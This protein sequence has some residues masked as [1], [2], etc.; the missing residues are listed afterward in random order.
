MHSLSH[1]RI[2]DEIS[3][4]FDWNPPVLSPA[5]PPCAEVVLPSAFYHLHL[6]ERLSL[7]RIIAAPS[8]VSDLSKTVDRTL[9]EIQDHGIVLTPLKEDDLFP[10]PIVRQLRV[11]KEPIINASSVAASYQRTTARHCKIIASMLFI[12]PKSPIWATILLWRQFEGSAVANP[13]LDESYALQMLEEDDNSALKASSDLWESID[14]DTRLTLRRAAKKYPILAL[15][16]VL[17]ITP[18]NEAFLKAAG[19]PP[20]QNLH[21]EDSP[22]VAGT[23]LST[24]PLH[25]PDATTLS[26]G[27]PISS[28]VGDPSLGVLSSGDSKGPSRR[29]SRI[30]KP[31]ASIK[32]TKS[33]ATQTTQHKCRQQDD[34]YPITLPSQPSLRAEAE[35]SFSKS[36][37]KHVGF[38]L[39]CL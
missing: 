15:W 39:P 4:V 27:R 36:L 26:W 34:L 11:Y 17:A 28:L 38:S 37:L 30:Q 31:H 23:P 10:T 7:K 24:V 8:L 16:E 22:N 19:E 32:P 1:E 6:D 12:S 18:E 9:K 13:G 29:S 25:V 3:E 5:A 14:Y 21:F 35:R 2:L 20:V 33:L